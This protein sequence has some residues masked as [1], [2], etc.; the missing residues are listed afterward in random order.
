[1]RR[2]QSRPGR[3]NKR[4]TNV[5]SVA[6]LLFWLLFWLFLAKKIDLSLLL[7]Y[8]QEALKTLFRLAT[9]SQ[10]W[11]VVLASMMRIIS[12]FTLAVVLGILLGS[13]TAFFPFFRPFVALPMNIIKATP[14]ASFVIL[15]LVWLSSQSLSIFICFLMVLPLVWM[16]IEAGLLQVDEDLLEM[17]RAYRFS[18]G[19]TIRTIYLP[20]VRP[21][22]ANAIILGFGYAWKSGVAA[23]VLGLTDKSI[24]AKLYEAKIYLETPELFAWTI[25]VIIISL[26]AENAMS[27]LLRQERRRMKK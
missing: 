26:L 17:A 16:N 5:L 3:L 14:V 1:M 12:G 2:W 4:A 7:P 9:T 20:A 8:P 13:L 23:E 19:K 6:A 11:L 22:F 24:G 27:Y 10:F 21:F 15:A 25:V 18:A